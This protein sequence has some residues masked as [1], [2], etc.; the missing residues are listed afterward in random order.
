L[1]ATEQPTEQVESLPEG[2]KEETREQFEKL[3]EHNKQLSEK[4]KKFEQQ[5]QFNSVLDEMPVQSQTFS[6]LTASQAEDPLKGL[7]DENGYIDQD[8]LAR[9]VKEAKEAKDRAMLAE[10]RIEKFEETQLVRDVHAKHPALDPYNPSFNREFYDSV[11]QEIGTQLKR[12][13]QDFA[14]A[15]DKVRAELEAKSQATNPQEEEAKKVIS[16]REQASTLSTSRGPVNSGEY[17][18]LDEGIRKGDNLSIGQKL[19]ASGY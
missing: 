6:D 17:E 10:Q 3:K 11:K 9:T 2:A 1:P 12:G 8:L 5:P 7:V 16:Q 19:Q 18:D 13:Y 14:A 15:A 4:L